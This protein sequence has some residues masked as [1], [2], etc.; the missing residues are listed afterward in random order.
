MSHLKV[1]IDYTSMAQWI[2]FLENNLDG[3]EDLKESK[4]EISN[5]RTSIERIK[6]ILEESARMGVRLNENL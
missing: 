5:I 4:K 1:N 6:N 2:K 3:L